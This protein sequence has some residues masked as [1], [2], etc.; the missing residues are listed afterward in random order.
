MK[1]QLLLLLNHWLYLSFF[2]FFLLFLLQVQITQIMESSLGFLLQP[3][4][5]LQWFFIIVITHVTREKIL[6]L[7]E[8]LKK[9]FLWINQYCNFISCWPF[10]ETN[11]FCFNVNILLLIGTSFRFICKVYV[12]VCARQV[13]EIIYGGIFFILSCWHKL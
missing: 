5:W 7:Q 6:K 3:L 4:S 12:F 2:N 8:L 11:Y 13:W 1:S 10:V 9:W